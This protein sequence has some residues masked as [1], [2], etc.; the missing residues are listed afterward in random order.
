[1]MT[2]IPKTTKG[3]RWGVVWITLMEYRSDTS[4]AV[5]RLPWLGKVPA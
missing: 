2:D 1:M 5:L 3:R 4:Y